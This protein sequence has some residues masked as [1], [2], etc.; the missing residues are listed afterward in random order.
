MYT[1]EKAKIEPRSIII[2]AFWDI[3]ALGNP[4]DRSTKT[5][6]DSSSENTGVH[7][8]FVCDEF[9]VFALLWIRLIMIFSSPCWKDAGTYEEAVAQTTDE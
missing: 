1:P 3:F 5:V 9:F 4:Q 6:E 2:W 8:D 7:D